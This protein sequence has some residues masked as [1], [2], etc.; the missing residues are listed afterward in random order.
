MDGDT[1]PCITSKNYHLYYS[2]T[3][4]DLDGYMC[5]EDV[6]LNDDFV[7]DNDDFGDLSSQAPKLIDW[8]QKEKK[9]EIG[10]NTSCQETHK[11]LQNETIHVTNKLKKA[12]GKEDISYDDLINLKYGE[13]SEIIQTFLQSEIPSL[14]N[15]YNKL[16]NFIG[17]FYFI[18]SCGKTP[19]SILKN[20]HASILYNPDTMSKLMNYDEYTKIWK[21]ISMA[22]L[23][24]PNMPNNKIVTSPGIIPFWESLQNSIN[25]H[26]RKLYILD[27]DTKKFYVCSHKN[28]CKHRIFNPKLSQYCY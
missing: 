10:F 22:G 12:C 6:Q 4:L 1:P 13:D 2:G 17:T 5:T 20:T 23:K 3:D 14:K 27:W 9:I 28:G 15:N 8:K 18:S 21:E 11:Q 26:F 25:N 7:G 24:A 16:I 19:K